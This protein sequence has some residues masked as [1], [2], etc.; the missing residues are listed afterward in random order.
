M[1]KTSYPTPF[2]GLQHEQL[3][4]LLQLVIIKQ[5]TETKK[6]TINRC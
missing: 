1:K 3:Q 4:A 6:A 2:Q 5:Q